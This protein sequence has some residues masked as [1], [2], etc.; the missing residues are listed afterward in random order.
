MC[1][2]I[3]KTYINT[4][5]HYIGEMFNII[6]IDWDCFVLF[7]NTIFDINHCQTWNKRLT[8]DVQRSVQTGPF[9]CCHG[10]PFGLLTF[11]T[12]FNTGDKIFN[13]RSFFAIVEGIVPRIIW[14]IFSISK[15]FYTLVRFIFGYVVHSR[16]LNE[17]YF[18]YLMHQ[19]LYSISNP[20]KWKWFSWLPWSSFESSSEVNCS[21]SF[22]IFFI[23]FLWIILR[24]LFSSFSD[25]IHSRFIPRFKHLSNLKMI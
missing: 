4:N 21:A 14:H 3:I 5:S 23:L 7:H 11:Q 6:C 18:L 17:I 2:K 1:I 19:P 15:P 12:R 8:A 9:G 24:F 16:D 10:W 25:R 20:L 22:K 13:I